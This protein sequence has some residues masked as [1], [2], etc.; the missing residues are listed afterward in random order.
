MGLR[1]RPP[2]PGNDLFPGF[3]EVSEIGIGSLAT[4]FRAREV[5][6]RR[7]VALKLLNVRDASPRAIESFERESLAL[8]AVSSHPN[9]V[10]LFRNFRAVDDRPVLVLE[11]C[12]GSIADRL[13]DGSGLPVLEVVALGIKIAGALETA[14]RAGILHRD[15]KPQNILITEFGEPALADFGVAMLQSSTQ[16]TAGL[17]D[18]TTLHAAPELLEGGETSAATDVYELASTL[19]QLVA[20]R[21]AFRAYEGESPASVILRILR[22]PVQPLVGAGVPPSLS[23]LLI[24]SMSKDK[25]ARPRTAEQFAAELAEI[26]AAQGWPRTPFFVRDAQVAS[27][28]PPPV[29]LG[30]PQPV[31]APRAPLA[32]APV[33]AEPVVV[34]PVA[35]QPVVEPAVVEPEPEPVP[36]GPGRDVLSIDDDLHEAHDDDP[37]VGTPPDTA[38]RA[39]STG[40]ARWAPPPED[41]SP[42]SASPAAASRPSQTPPAFPFPPLEPE[43]HAAGTERAFP[44]APAAP[45]ADSAQA[46]MTA[47]PV[48]T[49]RVADAVPPLSAPPTSGDDRRL[50]VRSGLASL[51]A[52][53]SSLRIRSGL[54]RIDLA[55]RDIEGFEPQF[56]RGGA[57]PHE[58]AYLV[59]LTDKGR[60]PLRAT[61]RPAADLQRLHGILDDYRRRGGGRR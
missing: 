25:D 41:W 7:L 49:S 46:G 52:D 57:S 12:D 29:H 56:G 24:Q 54:R 47:V 39:P 26:E 43:P 34:Q 17:F 8:G 42:E 53:P 2:A 40:A 35:V 10:T 5:D 19:Y 21:S 13:R 20:G 18:F 36:D 51:V 32:S 48:W 59:A 23:D 15:V 1:R 3:A 50:A 58:S 14:H 4:V 31:L 6:T 44:I 30:S 11:L 61:R 33:D 28:P 37:T 27:Q 9:I 45:T 55:W 38:A 60:I 16:T 22:D